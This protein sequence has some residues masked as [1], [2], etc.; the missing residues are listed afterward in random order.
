MRAAAAALRSLGA[1]RLVAAVPVGPRESGEAL[2]EMVDEVVCVVIPER[3]VAVG[4]WYHDF[5]QTSDEEVG[6]LLRRAQRASGEG[7]PQGGRPP[8][9]PAA[10]S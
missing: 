8:V 1:R 4:E 7:Q 9:G 6:A 5:S 10:G 3:F 2:R